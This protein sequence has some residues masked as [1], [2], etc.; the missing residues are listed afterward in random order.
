MEQRLVIP[1]FF[2]EEQLHA[3]RQI[4][5]RLQGKDFTHYLNTVIEHPRRTFVLAISI[6]DNTGLITDTKEEVKGP[7]IFVPYYERRTL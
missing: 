6:E 1:D 4:I 2:P 5:E 7:T 3:L